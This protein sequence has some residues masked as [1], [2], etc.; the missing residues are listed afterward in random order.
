MR[1]KP[2]TI[3]S[4]Q[5]Q[6][7]PKQ[8]QWRIIKH[9]KVFTSSGVLLCES[10]TLLN[11]TQ[12]DKRQPNNQKKSC[13]F[14]QIWFQYL[15]LSPSYFQTPRWHPPNTPCG[16]QTDRMV[17]AK[18]LRPILAGNL[19]RVHSRLTN[20]AHTITS[21]PASTFTDAKEPKNWPAK[22]ALPVSSALCCTKKSE[23]GVDAK[24]N[25]KCTTERRK[26]IDHS[27]RQAFFNVE[28]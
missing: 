26:D 20:A 9:R 21:A 6:T 12:P 15:L 11:S 3:N 8:Q 5:S 14:G 17:R 25:S 23:Q 22:A 28:Q 7:Q 16:H 18:C 4:T 1:K 2:T 10:S 27:I 19:N 13:L 24:L